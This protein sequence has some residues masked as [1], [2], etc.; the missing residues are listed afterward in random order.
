MP[1]KPVRSHGL[2]STLVKAGASYTMMSL[3]LTH[4]ENGHARSNLTMKALIR[5]PS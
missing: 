3:S 2:L 4:G 5:V 1:A